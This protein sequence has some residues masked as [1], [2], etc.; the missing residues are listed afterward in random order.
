MIGQVGRASLTLRLTL[1]FAFAAS[2]VLAALGMLLSSALNAHFRELDA[3]A[4]SGKLELVRHSIDLVHT[5][6]ELTRLPERL[7]DALVG[8]PELAVHIADLGGGILFANSQIGFPQ[9]LLKAGREGR[10]SKSIEWRQGEKVYRGISAAASLNLPG[11]REL[12][13][14][15]AM[16]TDHHEKF[17]HAIY[18]IVWAFVGCAGVLTGLLGWA[19]ARQGLAPL[20]AMREKASAITAQ[21]LD[22]R[23]QVESVPAEL[24][25]LARALNAMLARLEDAFT[26]LSEFSS[27]L[28]HELRTPISNL[29]MQTQVALARERSADHYRTILESNAEEFD[30]LARMVSDMLFLAKAD[31]G[32]AAPHRE[33]LDLAQEIRNLFDYYDALAE[34]RGI[35]LKSE[36][37]GSVSGDK[38]MI[39]RA[40][41]NLLSNAIRH[42]HEGGC[43]RIVVRDDSNAA[44]VSVANKGDAISAEHLERIFDRFYRLD[45]SRHCAGEG[46]GLGLAITRSIAVAHGGT[47]SA[48]SADGTTTFTLQVPRVTA[49]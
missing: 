34:Q 35:A 41:S 49:E 12:V 1:L 8:H 30:R 27:D 26:R 46:A 19:A 32:L 43:V 45:A 16:D 47:V 14:G 39:R 25:E 17:V 22:S 42:S 38:L 3:M 2:A 15:I 11:R 20:R 7:E 36:G 29:M 31:H 4:L 10:I 13:I 48:R 37:A 9:A 40:L 33:L 24:A 28:A 23:L 6:E 21:R 44:T 5:S 18:G